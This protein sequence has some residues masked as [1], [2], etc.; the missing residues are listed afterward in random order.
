MLNLIHNDS[1]KATSVFDSSA[2]AV[3]LL[4]IGAEDHIPSLRCL[5]LSLNIFPSKFKLDCSKEEEEEEEEEKNNFKHA[6][7]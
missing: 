7:K 2:P 1:S 3:L 5:I 4:C 6:A